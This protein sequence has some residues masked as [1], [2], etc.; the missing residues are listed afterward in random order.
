MLPFL[1][2]ALQA[3]AIQAA[4]VFGLLFFLGFI[5]FRLQYKTHRNY[6]RLFGWRG[7]YLTA[8]IGTPVH[9]LS[10]ALIAKIFRHKVHHV[11]L[12][13]PNPSTGGLGHIEHSYNRRSL[14]QQIG[15]AFIGAAPMLVGP[16]I[17]IGLLHVLMPEF[18][19]AWAVLKEQATISNPVDM[20][21]LI[22][23]LTESLSVQGW[24]FWLF[25]YLSFCIVSHMAPSKPDRKSM[26]KGLGYM[27]V[28]VFV[29]NLLA[30][31][32]G[33]TQEMLTEQVTDISLL[34]L[35]IYVYALFIS[36]VHF[37]VSSV[38]FFPGRLRS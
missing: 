14:Y 36:F 11:A 3:T 37:T 13:S 30:L 17:L 5:L 18:P 1:I 15:N 35:A 4:A 8:W 12:F 31:F 23:E 24:K 6:T 2:T 29:L 22:R 21:R 28:T 32:L 10:H 7:L 26:W 20:I 16:L 19:S 9:E 34:Y 25:L 33:V 38:L 27:L